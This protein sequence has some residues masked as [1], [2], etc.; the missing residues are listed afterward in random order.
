MIAAPINT[1]FKLLDDETEVILIV[2]IGNDHPAS[3]NVSIKPSQGIIKHDSFSINLGH[4]GNL[5]L[6]ELVVL[7]VVQDNPEGNQN[8]LFV[9]YDIKQGEKIKQWESAVLKVDNGERGIF[10]FTVVFFS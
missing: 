1:E 6:K 7:S 3:S 5:H 9:N 10:K 8:I 2:S 4:G